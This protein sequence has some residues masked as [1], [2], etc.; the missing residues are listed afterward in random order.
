MSSLPH[1]YESWPRVST[2]KLTLTVVGTPEEVGQLTDAVLHAARALGMDEPDMTVAPSEIVYHPDKIQ[3][4]PDPANRHAIVPVL[5]LTAMRELCT[6]P[7]SPHYINQIARTLQPGEYSRDCAVTELRGWGEALGI[8][9]AGKTTLA[10]YIARQG[11]APAFRRLGPKA[12][13]WLDSYCQDIVL[14]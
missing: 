10:D 7:S 14:T 13:T 2:A 3:L 11:N 5:G 12:R 9:V 8:R 6:D 1:N 4:L